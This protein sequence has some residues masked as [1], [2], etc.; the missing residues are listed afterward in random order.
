MDSKRNELKVISRSGFKEEEIELLEIAA[1]FFLKELYKI[2]KFDTINCEIAV[3]D[4]VTSDSVHTPICGDMEKVKNTLDNDDKSFYIC[5]L[6]DYNSAETIRTLAHEL[7]HVWQ[8]EL[9]R[10]KMSTETGWTWL[11]TSYGDYPYNGTDD[12]Y[13]LPWEVEADTMDIQ[14]SKKFYKQY[15]K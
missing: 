9:G 10:L 12:D 2:R 7:V 8:V 5:R 14:L 3:V 13:L 1:H 15:F 6:A 4:K 11:G